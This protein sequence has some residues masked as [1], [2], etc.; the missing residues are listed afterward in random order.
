MLTRS[1]NITMGTLSEVYAWANALLGEEHFVPP[2]KTADRYYPLCCLGVARMPCGAVE[3]VLLTNFEA[4]DESVDVGEWVFDSLR[5]LV[6]S[7]L[8]AQQ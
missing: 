3:S 2:P 1:A 6:R 5:A 7:R 8:A 4:V